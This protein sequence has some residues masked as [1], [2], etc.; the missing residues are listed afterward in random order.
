MVKDSRP[1]LHLKTIL[2]RRRRICLACTLRY[3][4]YEISESLL[5]NCGFIVDDVVAME[6]SQKIQSLL[7]QLKD[8]NL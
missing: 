3:T 8:L 4:T 2:T 6:K 7:K 1:S 5:K